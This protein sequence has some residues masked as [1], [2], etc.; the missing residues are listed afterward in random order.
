MKNGHTSGVWGK[1]RFFALL[2]VLLL[3]VFGADNVNAENYPQYYMECKQVGYDGKTFDILTT[4]YKHTDAETSTEVFSATMNDISE[5]PDSWSTVC[6]KYGITTDNNPH[7]EAEANAFMK[8]IKED[9]RFVV[10]QN[11][12]KNENTADSETDTVESDG[13]DPC[14]NAGLE[15]M[16]WILCPTLNN[17]KNTVSLIDRMIEDWMA[18][19][20]NLYSTSYVVNEKTGEVRDT[21][22]YIAWGYMRDIANVIMVLF[23]LFIIVSQVTGYGIDN[24]GIKKMLPKLIIMAVLINLSYLV[25]QLAIDVSN[26]L[27][28]G[29]NQ[30]FRTIG[31]DIL[32]AGKQS[33]MEG[34]VGNVITSVF[35]AVGVA[36][37]AAPLAISIIGVAGGEGAGVM[38]VILVVLA[39]LVALVAILLFFVMLGARM[40][41]IIVCTAVAPVAFACYILPNT[42]GYFKKWWNLFK[43]LLVMFPICGVIGGLGYMI[44]AIVL[45]QSGVH[46]WMMV[47]A[48]VVPYLPMFL[49][50]SLLKSA[51]AGLGKVG[52]ALTTLGNSVRSGAKGVG[53][54][55]HS[56]DR[57]KNAMQFAKD[58]AAAARAQRVHDRLSGQANLSRSQQDRLRRADDVI[59][60]QRKRTKENESRATGG[61]YDAMVLKQDTEA[62]SEEAAVRQYSDPNY[63]NARRQSID[64]GIRLQQ[65]KDETALAMKDFQGMGLEQMTSAWQQAFRN[66]GTYQYEDASGEKRT[67]SIG[68]LT[69]MMTQRYGTSAANNIGQS[70]AGMQGVAGNV[71]YQSSLRQLRQTMTDN[72]TFA[73]HMKNKASDA[74]QM[75]SEAGAGSYDPKTGK[76]EYKDLSH[77]SM[78]NPISTD[79]KDW[80]TQSAATLQRAIDANKIDSTKGLSDEMVEQIMTSTDPAIQSSI[81][82]DPKKR[83]VL[84]ARLYERDHP[85]PSGV[86]PTLDTKGA[87][88][89]YRNEQ[90]T[91]QQVANRAAQQQ[92]DRMAQNIDEI[93]QQLHN[94]KGP[95]NFQ[96]GAGI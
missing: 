75:I 21:G 83:D 65:S 40:V 18:V 90:R 15:S 48:L 12:A 79:I 4:V 70:L 2:F 93:N 54:V 69:N 77:F 82:S 91:Q 11:T 19:D 43:S 58:S 72:S 60:A 57:Y 26:I 66:G 74:Y 56:T 7:T 47:F 73:G 34:F 20:T 49:L 3:P 37:A 94:R 1:I 31:G 89:R 27:G 81:Q 9:G 33:L 52:A 84:Q 41:G 68:A 80:S 29:L 6:E 50:P 5:I 16:A 87:A 71:N 28:S 38:I 35:A 39:L 42:Q 61:F 45:T 25:C 46:L 88:V 23:L 44:K 8:K 59:L 22:A 30:M 85:N 36:G 17:T 95:E 76:P 13:T 10:S 86:G 24:Y 96:D 78:N 62:Y 32:G 55:V 14:Y 92:F 53:D 51:I 63:H 67:A 64:E